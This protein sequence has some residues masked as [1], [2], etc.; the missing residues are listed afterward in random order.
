MPV[1]IRI[2]GPGDE[3]V[4]SRV[5][6][7]VFDNAINDALTVEFLHDARHHIA[8]AIEDDVAVGFASALHYIHP[9]KPPELWINEVSVAPTHRKHGVGKQL[10]HALFG[11]GREHGCSAAWVLT[12]R[13]NAPAMRLYTSVGGVENPDDIVM[14]E[15]DIAAEKL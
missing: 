8:V 9:D 13:L 7:D 5:A 10:L 3:A 4:L 12:D 14:Y 1:E 6:P 15:F 11:V 2:L